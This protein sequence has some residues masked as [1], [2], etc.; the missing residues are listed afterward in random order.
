MNAVAATNVAGLSR[1]RLVSNLPD[2]EQEERVAAQQ[3]RELKEAEKLTKFWAAFYAERAT[4]ASTSPDPDGQGRASTVSS[5]GALRRGRPAH[6][7]RGSPPPP[8][9]EG[10]A[11]DGADHRR[12]RRRAASASARRNPASGRGP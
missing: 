7:A 6:P 11:P 1:I 4:T 8:L 12:G 9:V 5:P 10:P 2:T 3:A